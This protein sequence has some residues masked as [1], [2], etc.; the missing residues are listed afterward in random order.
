MPELDALRFASQ[1]LPR[2]AKPGANVTQMHYARRGEITPEM[3]FVALR[4]GVSAAVR[5]RRDRARPRRAAQ[6]HQPSRD[7]SR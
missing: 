2:V 5:A 6:Q 7:A 1:R 4:E 3:E